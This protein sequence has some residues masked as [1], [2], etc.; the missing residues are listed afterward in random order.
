MLAVLTFKEAN[1]TIPIDHDY[2]A[3]T[4]TGL[5]RINSINPTLV[6][7]GVGE[8]EIAAYTAAS[9]RS[10]GLDTAV[11]EPEPGRPSVV[12]R[13]RG[14]GGGPSL[15]LNA[16]YDTV[17]VE[18]MAE[19]FSGAVRDGRLY[20]R[21]AYDMKG[22]LAAGMAAAKALVDSG[23]PLAGDL[24][25]AAVADEEYASLGTADLIK[26]YDVDAA[27]V[28]EPTELDICLAHKGFIW[29]E[30]ETLGR[31][32][33]GSRFDLGVDA[34]MRMGRF[35]A[36]LDKLEQALRARPRH[37]LAGPPSLH[38][39][40]IEGGAE[41]SAY[42]ARCRLQI[43]R[44]T[45]PGETEGQVLAELQAI[46]D[47]LAAADPSFQATLRSFFVREPFEVSA[48]AN[49]VQS[50]AQAAEGVLGRPAN[51]VGQTPWMDSALLA[52][53]GVETVIIGP[54][55]AGA[56]SHEEWVEME[57]VVKLAQILAETIADYVNNE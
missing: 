48:E 30:V 40:T 50:L 39:A 5:V 3:E 15:M 2:L 17:G 8:A 21:G 9:L 24:L 38:A 26:R 43:E 33:H 1:M 44:R 42:A 45:I 47:R 29:L 36:E 37:P 35:L 51:M 52:A 27:I 7:G 54:A 28:T 19:P 11:H 32:A 22:S 57:S 56:H 12:G 41:L 23:T 20:G 34:N 14:S 49:I 13:M 6:P 46:I 31:A 25:V 55:G 18:G 53:A 10:I 16:H 4:L